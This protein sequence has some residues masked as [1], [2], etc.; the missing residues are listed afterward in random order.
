[1]KKLDVYLKNLSSNLCFSAEKMRFP[2][3]HT[4]NSLQKQIFE[5]HE[6]KRNFQEC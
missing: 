3:H 4:D 2:S 5:H 1:M 6:L